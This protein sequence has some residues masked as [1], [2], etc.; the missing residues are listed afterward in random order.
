MESKRKLINIRIQADS[1]NVSG[2]EIYADYLSSKTTWT[3]LANIAP[4]GSYD[5]VAHLASKITSV[6]DLKQKELIPFCE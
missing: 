4:P 3:H 2:N 5:I 1:S 6:K